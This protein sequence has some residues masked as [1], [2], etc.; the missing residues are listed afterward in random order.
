M[1]L[2]SR[3]GSPAWTRGTERPRRARRV[4]RVLVA[5]LL[6]ACFAVAIGGEPARL[7]VENM[8][9][10]IV[11]VRVGDQSFPGV[12]P[13]GSA[14][15][16]SGGGTTVRATVSYAAGQGVEGTAERSFH[17]AQTQSSGTTVYWAC[18][19]TSGPTA[20]S[21]P[22]PVYWKVTPDTLAGR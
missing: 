9:P 16:T 3:R 19:T 12:A 6:F 17:L 7:R 4:A 15:Y 13:G 22:G 8:T 5:G 14:I 18:F 21:V 2:T 11:D 1:G 10:R 20:P